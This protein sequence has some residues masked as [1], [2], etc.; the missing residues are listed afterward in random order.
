[1][2]TAINIFVNTYV[3]ELYTKY[4]MKTDIDTRAICPYNRQMKIDLHK[5]LA[6]IRGAGPFRPS[7]RIPQPRCPE[8]EGGVG[9]EQRVHV[10]DQLQ[11]L[12]AYLGQCGHVGFGSRAC[13]ATPARSASGKESVIISVLREVS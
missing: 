13:G 11:H 9:T 5:Q 10:V 1:M 2:H 3:S 7:L 12:R 6:M 4:L 8:Q